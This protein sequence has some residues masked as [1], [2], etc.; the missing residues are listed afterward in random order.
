MN[1]DILRKLIFYFIRMEFSLSNLTPWGSREGE[2]GMF[3]MFPFL[4]ETYKLTKL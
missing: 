2:G 3:Q 4:L 1:F